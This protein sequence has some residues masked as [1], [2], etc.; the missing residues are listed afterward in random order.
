VHSACSTHP[1]LS[2]KL[3]IQYYVVPR[4]K[5]SGYLSQRPYTRIKCR[6][7]AQNNLP[8][9]LRAYVH[10][11]PPSRLVTPISHPRVYC[12]TRSSILDTTASSLTVYSC[13]SCKNTPRFRGTG[14]FITSLVEARPQTVLHNSEIYSAQSHTSKAHSMSITV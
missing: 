8:H 9:Q 4:P 10:K 2:I 6:K 7:P 12:N 5:I 13:S 14:R 1:A 3:S 11:I